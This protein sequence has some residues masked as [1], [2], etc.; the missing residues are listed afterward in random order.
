MSIVGHD[1]KNCHESDICGIRTFVEYFKEHEQE[2]HEAVDIVQ[3]RLGNEWIT[4]LIVGSMTI[5]DASARVQFILSS[6]FLTGY[7]IGKGVK[8]PEKGI[9]AIEIA[10]LVKHFMSTE[11]TENQ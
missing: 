5:D 9:D 3:N 6:A 2:Y 1:C 10:N 7:V 11:P 4:K 8:V